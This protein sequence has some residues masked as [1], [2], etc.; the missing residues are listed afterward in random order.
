MAP[1]RWKVSQAAFLGT[2]IGAAFGAILIGF[3]WRSHGAAARLAEEVIENALAFGVAA[4]LVV[5]MRNWRIGARYGERSNMQQGIPS[6]DVEQS[7]DSITPAGSLLWRGKPT[8]GFA[9]RR[10][11][12][13][14]I[15]GSLILFV[16]AYAVIKSGYVDIYALTFND[17]PSTGQSAHSSSV[18]AVALA[19]VFF[20]ALLR[21][22]RDLRRSGHLEYVLCPHSLTIVYRRGK[23]V[24]GRDRFDQLS[25]RISVQGS[26]ADILI[27]MTGAGETKPARVTLHAIQD[28]IRVACLIRATLA[29]HTLAKN[30]QGNLV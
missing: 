22:R 29:P 20:L 1:K 21:R 17:M 11:L 14:L 24:F 30:I 12:I 4:V 28:P 10:H 15:K 9:S 26:P 25:M 3:D 19:F 6:P 16:V 2:A 7:K 18:I 23:E 8:S 5:Q 13:R 27:E